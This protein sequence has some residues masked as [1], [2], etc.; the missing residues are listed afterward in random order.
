MKSQKRHKV[1]QLRHSYELMLH[2]MKLKG[3]ANRKA[4][5][6]IASYIIGAWCLIVLG[7]YIWG[8]YH[9]H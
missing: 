9:V 2:Q 6:V 7:F 5:Y 8:V 1:R 4:S 3:I